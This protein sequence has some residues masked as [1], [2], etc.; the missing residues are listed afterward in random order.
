MCRSAFKIC[1]QFPL[2]ALY[3]E[4]SFGAV[5]LEDI[6]APECFEVERICNET[7]VGRCRLNR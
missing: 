4:P 3:L 1:F 7:M 2:A 5:N 6:K